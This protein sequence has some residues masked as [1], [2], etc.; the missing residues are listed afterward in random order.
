MENVINTLHLSGT[1]IGTPV[2]GHEAF[3]EKFYYLTLGVERLSGAQDLLPVTL[4]E[5]LLDGETL[6]EGDEL[7]IEGQVRSYN[8]IVEGTGRLLITA[9]AQRIIEPDERENPNQIQ[10]TGTLCKAP[11]YRTT[12][13]GREIADMMLAVNRAYGKSDYIPCITWGRSARFAAKL[14]VGD[15]ITLT[16]RLQSRAYQ[17][18]LADGTVIEKTAYEV[19]VGHLELINAEREEHEFALGVQSESCTQERVRPQ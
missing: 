13:F 5:R 1:V 19:S 7:T 9:F 6:K 11:A 4:S 16:G 17:K 10:L 12:P 18:Q 15:K 2:V 8:K 14:N 3:G